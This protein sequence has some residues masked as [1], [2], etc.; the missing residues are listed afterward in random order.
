MASREGEQGLKQ[1]PGKG[2]GRE[3]DFLLLAALAG[4]GGEQEGS[5]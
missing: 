1:G 4:Q 2:H 3:M 5:L